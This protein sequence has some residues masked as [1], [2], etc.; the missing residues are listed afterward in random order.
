MKIQYFPTTQTKDMLPETNI[1][2]P[3]AAAVTS[4]TAWVASVGLQD[5]QAGLAIVACVIAIGSGIFSMLLGLEKWLAMRRKRRFDTMKCRL[6]CVDLGCSETHCCIASVLGQ[7][8]KD[9]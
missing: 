2:S 9:D 8:A 7:K 5:V 4:L 6:W 3:I 1:A